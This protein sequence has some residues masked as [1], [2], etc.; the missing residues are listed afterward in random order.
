VA[1]LQPTINYL[2]EA[3]GYTDPILSILG[4]F[5]LDAGHLFANHN[6]LSGNYGPTKHYF[7]AELVFPGLYNVSLPDPTSRVRPYEGPG[8]AFR[9]SA[10]A[11]KAAGGN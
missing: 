7:S 4:P 11:R 5:A 2:T 3:L 8:G 10:A 6:L 1:R 9:D